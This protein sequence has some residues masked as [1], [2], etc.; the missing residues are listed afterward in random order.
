M[1]EIG[2]KFSAGFAM[3]AVTHQLGLWHGLGRPFLNDIPA[4]NALLRFALE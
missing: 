1:R 2:G 3:R 4:S